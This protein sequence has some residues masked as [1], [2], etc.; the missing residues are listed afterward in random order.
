LQPENTAG[1]YRLQSRL[2]PD[3]DAWLA[4][5]LEDPTRPVV[6]KFLP[7]GADAIAARHVVENLA[8]LA[9]HGL[10][11]PMDEGETADGRP[12]LVYPWVEGRTLRELMN[13]TGTPG[14]SRSAHILNQLGAAVS[15]LHEHGIVYGAISPE[16]IVIHHA[17]G[18]DV[19][20]LLHAGSYRV[21]HETSASPAYLAPEQ[22]AGGEALPASDVFS[23]AAVAA[24]MLTGRRVFRY[25]SLAELQHL[26]KKGVQRGAIRKLKPKLPQRVEDELRRALSTDPMQR[27]G[28]VRVFTGRL[29]ESLGAT[30]GLS[31]RRLFI[32]LLLIVASIY[33][34]IRRYRGR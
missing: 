18:R 28:E 26:H 17:H 12:Y 15:A 31:K 9:G 2:T 16:H 20:T 7:D 11:V 25:G 10:S 32:L 30:G 24:E 19:V 5:D 3:G 6:L 21:A 29:A 1:R 4:E 23:V 8:S 14:F 22:L 27:P 13:E 33:L 34:L